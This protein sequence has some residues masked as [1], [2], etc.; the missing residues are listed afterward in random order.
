M[1]RRVRIWAAP[2]AIG[3][4]SAAGLAAA[5]AF[6]G[7]VAKV[8]ACIALSTPALAVLWKLFEHRRSVR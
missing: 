5:L 8:G 1:T 2:V 6:E 3:A 7:D 4:T